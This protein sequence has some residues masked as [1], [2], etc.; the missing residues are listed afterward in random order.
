MNV[1]EESA[2]HA[3]VQGFLR[4]SIPEY[5]KDT[6]QEILSG[7]GVHKLAIRKDG[8]AWD[9]EGIVQGEDFQNYAPHLLFNLNDSQITHSC[10]C[11][12]A[13]M[14]VCRHVAAMALRLSSDLDKSAGTSEEPQKPAVEWRQSFRSFFSSSLEPETGRH[15]FIFRFFPEPGRLC[16]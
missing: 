3:L 9:V 13:F 8:D 4:D 11:H 10:N 16:R 14:G 6:G 5:I 15:Y 2:A 12:E 1:R 7:G